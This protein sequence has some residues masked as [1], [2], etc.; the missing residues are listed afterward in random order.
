MAVRELNYSISVFY[1]F[2]HN[3]RVADSTWPQAYNGVTWTNG[4]ALIY[5]E[6]LSDA[7][8][9][10]LPGTTTGAC[11]QLQHRQPGFR[12]EE[13]HKVLAGG[14][15]VEDGLDHSSWSPDGRWI[16]VLARPSSETYPDLYA[17]R[18]PVRPLGPQNRAAT[19]ADRV[20]PGTV[21]RLTHLDGW[22]LSQPRVRPQQ[23]RFR[24]SPVIDPRPLVPTGPF[25]SLPIHARHPA[26]WCTRSR[27]ARPA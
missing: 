15:C 24:A 25:Q 22:E 7:R 5:L 19:P 17:V 16:V 21:L 4:G 20:I 18:M 26:T 9:N 3:L 2:Q 14:Y 12:G 27:T 11:W 23:N 8:A 13:E 6:D 1:D 10:D